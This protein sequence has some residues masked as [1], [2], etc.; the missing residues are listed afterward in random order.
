VR[1]FI[2]VGLFYLVLC[3]CIIGFPTVGVSSLRR[4]QK[5]VQKTRLHLDRP[6]GSETQMALSVMVAM[7][8]AMRIHLA[9]AKTPEPD[10]LCSGIRIELVPTKWPC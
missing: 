4:F 9:E 1:P 8:Y 3:L 2:I 6:T 10:W 5:L 7:L